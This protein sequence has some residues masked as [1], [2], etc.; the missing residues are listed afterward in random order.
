MIWKKGCM[1]LKRPAFAGLFSLLGESWAVTSGTD[2]LATTT[3]STVGFL[4][5]SLTEMANSGS[6]GAAEQIIS[7]LQ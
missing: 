2:N 7:P 1:K 5:I 4:K 6:T 3:Q